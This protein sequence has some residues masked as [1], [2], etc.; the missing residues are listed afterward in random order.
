MDCRE[1]LRR[2]IKEQRYQPRL[3]HPP[4]SLLATA[5]TDRGT[6]PRGAREKG[7]KV[8]VDHGVE[9]VGEAGVEVV[10]HNEVRGGDRCGRAPA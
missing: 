8:G 3:R 1:Q 6:E 7:V 5:G 4:Q 9:L 2:T 10:G